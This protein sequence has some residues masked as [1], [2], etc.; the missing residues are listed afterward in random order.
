[1]L[2]H[3]R[4]K[5]TPSN[6]PRK[7]L[8]ISIHQNSH[9]CSFQILAQ[10]LLKRSFSFGASHSLHLRTLHHQ[11]IHAHIPPLYHVDPQLPL[12]SDRAGLMCFSIAF[13][14]T[15]SFMYNDVGNVGHINTASKHTPAL[16]PCGSCRGGRVIRA[17]YIF[18]L[19]CYLRWARSA[20][21]LS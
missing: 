3:T 1:M 20:G 4:S 12:G 15:S 8:K 16:V 21:G 13:S 9:P 7:P 10:I 18:I 19:S 11:Q 14:K 17:Q 5:I 2:H 6:L